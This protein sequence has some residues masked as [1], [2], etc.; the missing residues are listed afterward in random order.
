MSALKDWRERRQEKKPRSTGREETKGSLDAE[1][2][3]G[4][5]KRKPKKKRKRSGIEQEKEEQ[6]VDP[7][8]AEAERLQKLL[9]NSSKKQ[10]K[11]DPPLKQVDRQCLSSQS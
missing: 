8:Q 5:K 9:F 11:N 1:D 3:N 7:D 6:V 4:K 10:K 2:V